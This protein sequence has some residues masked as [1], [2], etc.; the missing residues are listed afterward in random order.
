MNCPYLCPEL[1]QPEPTA[2]DGAPYPVP[3]FVRWMERFYW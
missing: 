3:G 2:T 1:T